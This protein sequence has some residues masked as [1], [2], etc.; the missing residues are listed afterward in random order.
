MSDLLKQHQTVVLAVTSTPVVMQTDGS[1]SVTT[2]TQADLGGAGGGSTVVT[3]DNLVFQDTNGTLFFQRVSADTPPVLTSWNL[4]TGEAYTITG[5][6]TPYNVTVGTVDVV[7]SVLPTGAA[8][9]AEQVSQKDILT[10]IEERQVLYKLTGQVLNIPAG[11]SVA[12][13]VVNAATTRIV[14]TSTVNCWVEIDAVPVATLG[15]GTSTFLMAGVPS[16]PIRVQ[17][18][19][20]KVA[21]ISDLSGK[22]SIFE[23]Y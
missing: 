6:P 21:A 1:Q 18:G 8:T 16:Y 23:S 19:S 20:S 7:S 5:T 13:S 15:S 12:S 17:G 11:S 9:S 14:L 3:A 10:A 22:L 2:L 4:L